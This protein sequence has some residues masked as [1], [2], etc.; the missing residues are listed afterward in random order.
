MWSFA[1]EPELANHTRAIGTG[2]VS[3]NRSARSMVGM[4]ERWKNVW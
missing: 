2:A 3:S 4:F 1:S